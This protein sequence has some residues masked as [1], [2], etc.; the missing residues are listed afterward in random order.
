MIHT[1]PTRRFHDGIAVIKLLII[2]FV[3]AVIGAIAVFSYTTVSKNVQTKSVTEQLSDAAT[4]IEAYKKNSSIKAYP[5]SLKKAGVTDA[6]GGVAYSYTGSN[7]AYCLSGVTSD[8]TTY[9]VLT[10]KTTPETG[11]CA[12]QDIATDYSCF[13][14]KDVDGGVEITAYRGGGGTLYATN[15]MSSCPGDIKIPFT[16]SGK[17]VVAI[18]DTAFSRLYE[19]WSQSGFSIT[20]VSIP[21]SVTSIGMSAFSSNGLSTVAIPSSVQTIGEYAFQG[22]ALSAVTLSS[23]ITTVKLSAFQYNKLTYVE[24]PASVTTIGKY[25]FAGNSGI[26]CSFDGTNKFA[27]AVTGCYGETMN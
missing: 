8:A 22:N 5:S 10:G 20:A 21:D 26:S 12:D 19:S 23:G 14:T 16:I 13:E 6:T 27:D 11:S 7:N 4:K 17:Q 1:T 18:G 3:V 24:I 25:A 9:R 15:W 2:L